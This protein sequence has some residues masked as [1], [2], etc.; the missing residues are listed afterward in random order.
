MTK[1]I[2]MSVRSRVKLSAEEIETLK[3]FCD[4]EDNAPWATIKKNIGV[5]R[6]TIEAVLNSGGGELRVIIKIRDFVK[7]LKEMQ[8][9]AIN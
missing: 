1:G 6:V 3:A 5:A 8:A 7:A 2:K 9:T 4:N